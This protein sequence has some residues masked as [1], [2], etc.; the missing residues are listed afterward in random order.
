LRAAGLVFSLQPVTDSQTII[1]GVAE[2]GTFGADRLT[3]LR[4]HNSKLSALREALERGV[5]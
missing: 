2:P 5:P 1:H 4:Q 3:A